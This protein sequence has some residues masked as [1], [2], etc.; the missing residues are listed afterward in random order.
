C[1]W[2]HGQNS[3]RKLDQGQLNSVGANCN[4]ENHAWDWIALSYRLIVKTSRNQYNR[5]VMSWQA[6]LLKNALKMAFA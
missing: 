4:G 5:W 6:G 2:Y 3:S 1:W